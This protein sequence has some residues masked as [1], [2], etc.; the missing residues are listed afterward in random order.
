MPELPLR[1]KILLYVTMVLFAALALICALGNYA[2]FGV[3]IVSYV[4]A[5]VTLAAS[6]YYIVK[7]LRHG[8]KHIIK[9]GIAANPY[10]NKVATDDRFR[11][12]L[13]AVPGATSNVIFAV[14]NGVIGLVGR[15]AWF[16][17]LSAYYI[18][19]SVMRIGVVWQENRLRN[20]SQKEERM[21]KEI[22]VYRRNSILFI[23]MAVVLEGMV[24]LLEFSAGGKNYPGFT[25]YAAAAYTFYKIIKSLIKVIQEGKKKSPLIAILRKINYIDGCVSILTLQTAMFASFAQGQLEFVKIMNGITGTVVFLMVL[26]MGIQGILRSKKLVKNWRTGGNENGSY[27]SSGR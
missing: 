22:I 9:P 15:S 3:A 2:P 1:F 16:G 13:F 8:V 27:S 10:T 14:F 18:L 26:T 6:C 4:L 19:L 12:V 5:A 24:M 23:L 17:S 20:I 25:I 11:V 7:D 21:E